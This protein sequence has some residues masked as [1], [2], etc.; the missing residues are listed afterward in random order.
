[1]VSGQKIIF[2][3]VNVLKIIMVIASVGYLRRLL[4]G[5]KWVPNKKNKWDNGKMTMIL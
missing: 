5:G 3:W 2:Y 4:V 1:M